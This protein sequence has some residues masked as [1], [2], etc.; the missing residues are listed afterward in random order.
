MSNNN[1][2]PNETRK[3]LFGEV[4]QNALRSAKLS[5]QALSEMLGVSRNTVT[6]WVAD[7]YKPDHDLIPQICEIL[8]LTLSE[9]YGIHSKDELSKPERSV[10]HNYRLM[11]PTNQKAVVKIVS[12]ILDEEL[13]ATDEYLR[14]AFMILEFPRT[15][16]AA[17]QGSDYIDMPSDHVF[18]RRKDRNKKADAIIEVSGDSMLPVYKDGDFVYVEYTD[19]AYPGEDVVCTTA[20]G[21]VIKRLTSD[22]RLESVNPAFPFGD[23]DE[24]DNI[25]IIGRVLGVVDSRDRPTERELTS[26]RELFADEL[27]ELAK[28][29]Q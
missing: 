12:D 14:R 17:G 24:S 21:G 16:A 25:R 19:H 27:R 10:I 6:N 13:A 5:Q 9:L 7:K 4:I 22:Y 11:N 23:K 2:P 18:I 15:K 26:L 20:N 3:V 28:E 1:N 8:G 29:D